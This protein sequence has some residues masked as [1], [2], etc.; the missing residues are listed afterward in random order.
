MKRVNIMRKILIFCLLFVISF[1]LMSCKKSYDNYLLKDASDKIKVTIT[2][3]TSKEFDLFEEKIKTFSN[4]LSEKLYKK[5]ENNYV[6]SPISIYMA[7]AMAIEC[8]ND[9]TKN[10]MLDAVGVTYEEVLKY[11]IFGFL[12]MVVSIGTYLLFAK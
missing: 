11:L 9:T 10:E 4:R 5:S 2:E 8:A 6:I 12:T 1:S 3:S 7:L